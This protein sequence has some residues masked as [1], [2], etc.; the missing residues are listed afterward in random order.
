MASPAESRHEQIAVALVS[1]LKG[2]EAGANYH[3]QPE[4]VIRTTFFTD[5][6]FDKSIGGDASSFYLL[7]PGDEEFREEGTGSAADGGAMHAEAEF[8]LVL[9]RAHPAATENPYLEE[10]PTR[11]QV[12]NRMVRDVIKALFANVNLGLAFV[13]NII[14]DSLVV[15]RARYMNGWAVVELRFVVQYN[16]LA[17]TP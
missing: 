17:G 15:D 4:R 5:Q 3:Y 13:E 10:A 14:T 7:R 1:V 12:C 16:F 9:A 8:F 2:I 11:W 6:P